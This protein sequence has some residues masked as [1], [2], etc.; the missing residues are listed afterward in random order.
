ME[1]TLLVGGNKST[2]KSLRTIIE[3]H[4]LDCSVA[5]SQRRALYLVRHNPPDVVIMDKTSPRLSGN[6]LVNGLRR[7]TDVPLITITRTKEEAMGM[8]AAVSLV[9]PYTEQQLINSI[10]SVLKKYPRQLDAGPLSLDLRT[11]EVYVPH[12]AKKERLTPKLFA[13]LRHLM[14]R[15]GEVVTRAELMSE[16]WK[17]QFVEDTR[18]LDVHI[19]WIRM[20]IEPNPAHPTYLTTVR[21]M[22]YPL[23]GDEN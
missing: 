11:R 3:Q 9:K 19:H 10:E 2:I 23:I 20:I 14:Y 8:G 21:G 1:Q 7:L 15:R 6:K 18:T 5:S 17:T 4:N 22:G 13:L 16:V 12:Q